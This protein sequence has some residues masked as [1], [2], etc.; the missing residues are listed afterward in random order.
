MLAAMIIAIGIMSVLSAMMSC[1]ARGFDEPAKR[2]TIARVAPDPTTLAI[3]EAIK[4]SFQRIRISSV[5]NR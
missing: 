5:N 2:R 1:D 3:N 4:S